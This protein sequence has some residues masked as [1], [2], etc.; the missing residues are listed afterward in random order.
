[1]RVASLR[2]GLMGL[3]LAGAVVVPGCASMVS[4]QQ[5]VQMGLQAA[6]QI[7][8][9]IPLLEDPVI[10]RYVANLGERLLEGAGDPRDVPYRFRVV[11]TELPSTKGTL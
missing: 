10:E 4:T 1:M 9:E 2:D 5:E 3:A 6:E 8:A 7:E 11:D